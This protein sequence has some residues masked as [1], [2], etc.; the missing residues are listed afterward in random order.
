VLLRPED[1]LALGAVVILIC[2]L[3]SALGVRLALKADPATALGG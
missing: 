1:G 3:S 2:V